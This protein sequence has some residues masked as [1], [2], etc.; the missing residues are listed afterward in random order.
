VDA[1]LVRDKTA[2]RLALRE[3]IDPNPASLMVAVARAMGLAAALRRGRDHGSCPAGR[4]VVRVA[5]SPD[6]VATQCPAGQRLR[7]L[8]AEAMLRAER[9]AESR[10]RGPRVVRVVVLPD[11]VP[12]QSPPDQHA[13]WAALPV[14]DQHARRALLPHNPVAEVAAAHR[15]TPAVHP[16]GLRMV[17]VVEFPDKVATRHP[18]DRRGPIA[19]DAAAVDPMAPKGPVIP[20]RNLQ[21]AVAGRR[22]RTVRRKPVNRGLPREIPLARGST[23]TPTPAVPAIDARHFPAGAPSFAIP[24]AEPS[25]PIRVAK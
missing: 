2:T 13:R 22:G 12:R 4:K 25:E 21:R 6:K 5:V 15:R 19:E 10:R 9:Q 7:K 23:A 18:A 20:E 16:P 3:T 1:R 17:R 8:T 11:K 24:T 14:T